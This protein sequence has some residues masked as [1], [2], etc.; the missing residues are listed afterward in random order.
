MSIID[1]KISAVTRLQ[2]NIQDLITEMPTSADFE[3]MATNTEFNEDIIEN[4]DDI[5]TSLS[6]VDD[7]LT[8]LLASLQV[9]ATEF[10]SY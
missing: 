9:Y 4:I 1:N 8:S 10:D 3:E 6:A 2:G 7:E 5:N